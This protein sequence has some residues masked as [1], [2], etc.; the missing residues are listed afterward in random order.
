MTD[1][2]IVDVSLDEAR[3]IAR[4]R[5][6]VW[7]ATRAGPGGA[8]AR[9]ADPAD[10]DAA[11]SVLRATVCR[12]ELRG[13]PLADRLRAPGDAE[14]A[15]ERGRR[16]LL[17]R[18]SP[19]EAPTAPSRTPSARRSSASAASRPSAA[20]GGAGA[21]LA[22][23]PHAPHAPPAAARPPT[24]PA[25][26]PAP[27]PAPRRRAR[28]RARARRPRA[29]LRDAGRPDAAERARGALR[30]WDALET[31][32]R[33]HA[34]TPP[35]IGPPSL[36]APRSALS[37][38][39]LLAAAPDRE[40]LRIQSAGRPTRTRAGGRPRREVRA[41]VRAAR[42]RLSQLA[43]PRPARAR[44]VL[45][46]VQ[47]A[48]RAGVPAGGTGAAPT[49]RR[50][51]PR[52]RRPRRRAGSP[53]PRSVHR[54]S[55]RRRPSRGPSPAVHRGPVRDAARGPLRA[56][57]RR[58]PAGAAGAERAGQRAPAARPAPRRRRRRAA[59][60]CGLPRAGGGG[61]GAPRRGRAAEAACN[62]ATLLLRGGDGAANRRNGALKP[63]KRP[64][65]AGR[66]ARARRAGGRRSPRVGAARP[67]R[68]SRARRR[69]GRGRAARAPRSTPTHL[70]AD[71]NHPAAATAAARSR[72]AETE[73]LLAEAYV[74]QERLADARALLAYAASHALRASRPSVWAR[75][76]CLLGDVEC[77]TAF[78]PELDGA[79]GAQSTRG[80]A[81][82]ARAFRPAQFDAGLRRLAAGRDWMRSR[83]NAG[84]WDADDG[85]L[86]DARTAS[87]VGQPRRPP[88]ATRR[89]AAGGG[90][91]PRVIAPPV[92]LRPRRRR[93]VRHRAG[94]DARAAVEA[95]G[96]SPR[97][98]RGPQRA[99]P[100]RKAETPAPPPRPGRGPAARPPSR[101]GSFTARCSRGSFG[102][103]TDAACPARAA[104]TR[105]GDAVAAVRAAADALGDPA[106]AVRVLGGAWD[107]ALGCAGLDA[108]VEG[109]RGPGRGRG[110][111]G[112]GLDRASDGVE[113][114]CSVRRPRGGALRAPR[115]LVRRAR[116]EAPGGGGAQRE[117]RA[118]ERCV[119]L[120]RWALRAA[121]GAGP[122]DVRRGRFDDAAVPPP[123]S[124]RWRPGPGQGSP[125]RR[126]ARAACARRTALS[127]VAG[128]RARRGRPPDLVAR[129]AAGAP[130]V[131]VPTGGSDGAAA[132]ARRGARRAVRRRG[133]RV[134]LCVP[135]ASEAASMLAA[136][137]SALERWAEAAQLL[138]RVHRDQTHAGP[139]RRPDAADGPRARRAA[140]PLGGARRRHSQFGTLGAAIRIRAR[141]RRAGEAALRPTPLP[142]GSAARGG[143]AG[144][145]GVARPRRSARGR[146]PAE[147][148]GGIDGARRGACG[149][150]APRP[151]VDAAGRLP[152][153]G[154][155]REG[156]GGRG[157]APLRPP[158]AQ[159]VKPARAAAEER[160]ARRRGRARRARRP[161]P[162]RRRTRCS[163]SW[164]RRTRRGP[165]RPP[166]PADA[167]G[168]AGRAA[169]GGAGRAEEG[170]KE[171]AEAGGRGRGGARRSRGGG[172]AAAEGRRAR[173]AAA[174]AAAQER[175]AAEARRRAEE[176]AETVWRPAS[177]LRAR[178]TRS[179]RRRW[180]GGRRRRSA[181]APRRSARAPRRGPRRGGAGGSS[182]AGGGGRA[183]ARRAAGGGRRQSPGLGRGSGRPTDRGGRAPVG[184]GASRP[185]ANVGF[186]RRAGARLGPP[187]AGAWGRPRPGRIGGGHSNSRPRDGARDP[188]HAQTF[189]SPDLAAR[190]GSA[191][192]APGGAR[193]RARSLPPRGR[194]RVPRASHDAARRPGSVAGRGR[195]GRRR[196]RARR[197]GR[198]GRAAAGGE[199][200]GVGR[201]H[202]RRA[203]LRSVAGGAGAPSPVAPPR[204]GSRL[205]GGLWSPNGERTGRDA[206]GRR[207]RGDAR[208]DARG[209]D[210][211]RP[212]PQ[213][214]AGEEP[215]RATHVSK[216]EERTMRE[217]TWVSENER[218]RT[219]GIGP[220]FSRCVCSSSRS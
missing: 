95:A 103:P 83:S 96:S 183:G 36:W 16:S 39:D 116:T 63:S 106:E 117:D 159:T 11:A 25:G 125:R 26:S 145:G 93:A 118:H 141:R 94:S 168:E 196:A 202:R 216:R 23:P 54:P 30:A 143:G 90:G 35:S 29:R 17:P 48:R 142:W 219:Y 82:R 115:R 120:S 134:T 190:R 176:A 123:R 156:S 181:R 188:A 5:R 132:R 64:R 104:C 133:R 124:P 152:A 171:A 40:P 147:A 162:T 111:G 180:R 126:R 215:A 84:M 119:N 131:A 127:R 107:D 205:L 88:S 217:R 13:S 189:A 53:A 59:A 172:A 201:Q 31:T 92:R 18:R 14:R 113:P 146:V 66:L 44:R 112:R 10:A 62:L 163:P 185:A 80:A 55:T 149:A 195:P 9:V 43:R 197:A 73:V 97:R 77:R 41:L 89:T 87:R 140:L 151:L 21:G 67:P 200:D 91:A 65:A 98:R 153:R 128:R 24:R 204:S 207:P 179:S 158:A 208:G 22:R 203:A 70:P 139:R 130:R 210:P 60:R 57:R 199:A 148:G 136:V 20:A 12:A 129:G 34:R 213:V 166:E 38:A 214:E 78:C 61:R 164:T 109:G 37:L 42:R 187:P 79:A 47:G 138:R 206:R 33:A 32:R 6:D 76:A 160:R 122:R 69:R 144:D 71:P 50:P 184:V 85:A 178:K 28:G 167:A 75:A 114:L 173:G 56:V 121:M 58:V 2:D 157:E 81:G 137:L 194:A 165:R 212:T 174:A 135:E 220:C 8:A 51:P 45:R 175:A 15:S 209:I 154:K 27:A 193:R 7:E 4:M 52:R 161:R 192:P 3:L 105:A 155:R 191:G 49:A 100:G 102:R 218:S 1:G 169:T 177:R 68:R 186:A 211:P 170:A 108:G 150:G 101:G 182:R 72:V 198:G 74:A 110:R 46:R 86:R 99:H 19:A